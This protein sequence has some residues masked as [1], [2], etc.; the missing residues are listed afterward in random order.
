MRK[1]STGNFPWAFWVGVGRMG[2]N[3]AS[4]AFSYFGSWDCLSS[5]FVPLSFQGSFAS[6]KNWCAAVPDGTL[7]LGYPLSSSPW[8]RPQAKGREGVFLVSR[9]GLWMGGRVPRAASC[10]AVTKL[11]PKGVRLTNASQSGCCPKAWCRKELRGET[12]I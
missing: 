12:D 4:P 5:G 11:S 8:K 10:P 1:F 3:R 7:A 2:K 9:S 6:S